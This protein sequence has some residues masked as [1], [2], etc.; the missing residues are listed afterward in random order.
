MAIRFANDD[1][2]KNWNTHILKNP[3]GGNFAQGQEF[4]DQKKQAGWKV[5][6]IFTE[7]LPA[8]ILTALFARSLTLLENKVY[9]PLKSS[10]KFLTISHLLHSTF[11][12]H[13]LFNIITPPYL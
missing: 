11:I 5:Q 4:A 13:G 3:D 6:Y 10:R 12:K 7:L 1:E 9:L 2:V 8:M